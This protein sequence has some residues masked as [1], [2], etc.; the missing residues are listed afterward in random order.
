MEDAETWA[1]Y[2]DSGFSQMHSQPSRVRAVA[3][4]ISALCDISSDLM[5]NFYH[6][7]QMDRP[8]GKQVELMRLSDIH[9]RLESWRRQ[10]PKEM[11]PREG[12]LSSVLVMQ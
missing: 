9:T 1:P 4:Q 5:K 3:L 2:T 12:G 6:P 11:E 7:S 8:I 10:L